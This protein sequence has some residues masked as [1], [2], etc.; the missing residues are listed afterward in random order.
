[1][2]HMKKIII[3]FLC[4]LCFVFGTKILWNVLI[5][6]GYIPFTEE[7]DRRFFMKQYEACKEE[8]E[9]LMEEINLY[10]YALPKEMQ[11]EY[12]KIYFSPENGEWLV[13][14]YAEEYKL[15]QEKRIMENESCVEKIQEKFKDVLITILYKKNERN[16]YYFLVGENYRIIISDDGVVIK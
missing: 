2:K 9:T 16:E 8:F 4:I 5:D 1:M 3:V 6:A 13:E 12:A 11:E 10:A 15:L 14:L 7:Y